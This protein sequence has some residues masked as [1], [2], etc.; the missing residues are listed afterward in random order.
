[1]NIDEM[2]DFLAEFYFEAQEVPNLED[3]VWSENISLPLAFFIQMGY[4]EKTEKGIATMQETYNY[5]R[6]LADERGIEDLFDLVTVED[7]LP[8][9]PMFIQLNGD[10]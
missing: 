4:A 1:M 7:K 9:R 6:Q 8:N 5:L 3:I 10:A 2:I